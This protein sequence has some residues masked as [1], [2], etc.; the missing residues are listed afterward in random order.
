MRFGSD[1]TAGAHPAIVD[2]IAREATRVDA[3]YG[4]DEQSTALEA[5]L[6]EIFEHDLR[7][8]PVV[9]G[10]A[11]NALA[12]AALTPPW[13]AI[14]CTSVAHVLADECG[15]VE[16][17]S[18]GARLVGLAHDHG[19]MRLDAFEAERDRLRHGVHAMPLAAMSLTQQTE[20]G[21]TYALD[22]LGAL[23]DAARAA[24]LRTH[25]DGARLPN[26]I[27][28]LGCSPGDATWR[29][30]IDVLSLGATKDGAVGADL[31]ITFDLALADELAFRQ[32]RAGHLLSK[33][34]FLAAQLLAWL[35]DDLWLSNA[36]HA[37]AMA[38]EIAG[39]VRS[40]A[41][42]G[43]ELVLEPDGNEVFVRLPDEVVVA[44][45]AAGAEFYEFDVDGEL[46]WR[47]VTSWSTDPAEVATLRTHLAS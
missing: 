40:C 39:A 12:L 21:T 18:G 2:A 41:T 38:A 19:R 22:A 24:G 29:S 6:A 27:T 1:N 34:R 42:S 9:T 31:I 7:V 36:A 11:A 8:F 4:N 17:L 20:L 43:V 37:N 44:L 3:A 32:K 28:S 5:R 23:T 13:G 46:V 35:D 10:T 14:V 33:Q 25:L 15:A 30:G 26:A 45:H 16:H 47:F